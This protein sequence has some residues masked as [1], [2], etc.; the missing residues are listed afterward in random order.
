MICELEMQITEKVQNT[1][2]YIDL[3]IPFW[4]L[5]FYV[6]WSRFVMIKI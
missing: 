6:S 5:F 4:L 1:H 3:I 2:K